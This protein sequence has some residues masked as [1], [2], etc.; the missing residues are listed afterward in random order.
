[1]LF[2]GI[3][4]I[5]VSTFFET[6]SDMAATEIYVVRHGQ[7]MGNLK[8]LFL[9]HTDLDLTELGYEQAE[10]TARHLDGIR[11]D[12]IYSSDLLRAFHTAECTARR[13]GLPVIP[14]PGLREIHAGVWEGVVFAQIAQSHP[15]AFEVWRTDFGNSYCP[16]GESVAELRQRITSTVEAI[17]KRHPGQTVFLFSHAV[18]IRTL[19]AAWAGL[20]ADEMQL[21]PW[22]TNASVSHGRYCDGKFTLLEYSRDDFMG[23]MVTAFSE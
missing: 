13:K 6:E 7:S 16:G 3:D 10:L 12:A 21:H 4:G 19:A 11:A 5:I 2:S 18:A 8:D 17:A 14:E 9:G 15:E 23:D 1:M 22:P 20:L